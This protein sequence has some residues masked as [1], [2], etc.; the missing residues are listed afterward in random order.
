[1][2]HNTPS[3]PSIVDQWR[4]PHTCSD[5]VLR[6]LFK[7]TARDLR[8][9]DRSLHRAPSGY[10]KPDLVRVICSLGDSAARIEAVRARFLLEADLDAALGVMAQRTNEYLHDVEQKIA[11]GDQ[12]D[13]VQL[14]G[15]IRGTI[16]LANLALAWMTPSLSMPPPEKQH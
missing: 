12:L 10:R 4:T 2:T 16:T 13:E 8:T 6:A 3:A 9:I 15:I 5:A 1:M 11:A 7:S 14:A